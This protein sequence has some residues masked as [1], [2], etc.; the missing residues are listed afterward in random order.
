M[1]RHM[2]R[3]NSHR[4]AIPA[5]ATIALLAI[6]TANAASYLIDFGIT[7]NPASGS[8]TASPDAVNGKFWNNVT[9]TTTATTIGGGT[10]TYTGFVDK[11]SGVASTVGL[12]IN[13]PTTG[14]NRWLSA[15][16]AQGGLN[17]NT[18]ALGELGVAT[19]TQ[20]FFFVEINVGNGTVGSSTLT[21][22]GLNPSGLY[23]F[24]LFGTRNTAET[25]FTRYSVT[26]TNGLHFSDLQTSGAG[27]GTSSTG[28]NDDL[29]ALNGLV[30]DGSGNLTLTVQ[31]QTSNFGYLGAMRITAVPEP[32]APLL[33]GLGGLAFLARRR[34]A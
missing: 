31:A 7:G 18:P 33:L 19:A 23:D 5:L 12:T 16:I 30:A 3:T 32:T 14:A 1:F 21:I 6:P 2:T 11:D 34:R 15:G 17:S 24:A 27:A 29:A 4:L 25:R 9:S 8:P 20:D 13:T 22:T 26:D 10:Y 28:N